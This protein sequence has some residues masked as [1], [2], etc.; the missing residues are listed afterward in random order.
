MKITINN[1]ELT[2]SRHK[3]DYGNLYYEVFSGD[4]KIGRINRTMHTPHRPLR[5]GSRIRRDL[6]PRHVFVIAGGRWLAYDTRRE[7]LEA[8]ID[9]VNSGIIQPA[10]RAGRIYVS[11]RA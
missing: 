5:P 11:T 10:E 3:D 2:L 6:T 9:R 7:A 8:L 1:H 4:V